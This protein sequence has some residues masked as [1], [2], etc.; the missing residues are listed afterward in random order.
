M[1]EGVGA[2]AS[3]AQPT[4]LLGAGGEV[5]D[6]HLLGLHISGPVGRGFVS[7]DHTI[8]GSLQAGATIRGERDSYPIPSQSFTAWT[9]ELRASTLGPWNLPVGAWVTLLHRAYDG[10]TLTSAGNRIDHLV[11]V[12]VSVDLDF[13]NL[14]GVSPTLGL[15]YETQSST[16]PLGRFN[17]VQALMG[18]E[19]VF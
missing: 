4:Y 5:G 1:E 6:S 2:A 17:R 16:D 10:P 18:A 15:I 11:A 19:K 3:Y 14:W 12:G 9:L 8:I 13:I 7:A